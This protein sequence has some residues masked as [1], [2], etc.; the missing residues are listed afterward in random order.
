MKALA[1]IFSAAGLLILCAVSLAHGLAFTV[2]QFRNPKA[3]RMTVW[4]YYPDV[5]TF[6]KLDEFQ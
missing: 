2:W 6:Q 3:N 5:I 1:F 4:T